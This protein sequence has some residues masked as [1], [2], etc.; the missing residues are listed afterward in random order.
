MKTLLREAL[1]DLCD[2]I[3]IVERRRH[4]LVSARAHVCTGD[5]FADYVP[6]E[7]ATIEQTER[8]Q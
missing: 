7:G 8:L 3:T 6:P 1:A 4:A 2:P 5:P